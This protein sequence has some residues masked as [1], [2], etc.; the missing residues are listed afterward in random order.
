ML[1]AVYLFIIMT[2]RRNNDNGHYLI[3]YRVNKTIIFIN[4]PTPKTQQVSPQRL[5]L[6]C[7][8]LGMLGQFQ[9]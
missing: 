2:F 6:S 7:F 4:T 3:L 8:G 9:K 1:G 5:D